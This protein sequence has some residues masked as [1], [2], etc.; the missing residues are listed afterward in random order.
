M[1]DDESQ[2]V[3]YS[4]SYS[5]GNNES[6]QKKES[7]FS[8]W[9]RERKQR[10]EYK[11]LNRQKRMEEESERMK[12][13]IA[14][15]Q[16]LISKQ[17]VIEKKRADFQKQQERLRKLKKQ[18]FQHTVLGKTIK[19][20][21]TRKSND[22]I[23]GS[24]FSGFSQPQTFS[25]ESMSFGGSLINDYKKKKPKKKSNINQFSGLPGLQDG[26]W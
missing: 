11:E 3:S 6:S 9:R 25:N 10:K 21:Q 2:S 1:T 15:E 8:K 13:K 18:R 4:S 17:L 16:E 12:A 5:I 23:F 14:K 19:K 22:T 26:R 20:L 7:I 24:G